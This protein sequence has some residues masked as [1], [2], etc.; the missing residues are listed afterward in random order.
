MLRHFLAVLVAV[1]ALGVANNTDH[2]TATDRWVDRVKQVAGQVRQSVHGGKTAAAVAHL[3][4]V[5]GATRGGR[6]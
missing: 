5:S 3:R 2:A 4:E 6:G 1:S